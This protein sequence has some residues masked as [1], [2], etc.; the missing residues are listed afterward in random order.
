[1]ENFQPAA[2]DAD[3]RSFMSDE[4]SVGDRRELFESSA[5]NTIVTDAPDRRFKQVPR[6]GIFNTTST[7]MRGT[8]SV[9]ITLMF[10]FCGALYAFAGTHL[11]IEFGL[12]TPRH[13]FEGEEQGIPRSG[14]ALNY[15]QYA[16]PQPAYRHKTVVFSACVYGISYIILGNAAGNC[17]IFG[18]RMLEAADV[19]VTNGK[20]RG[21]AIAV[22]SAACFVHAFSRRGGIW[23]SNFFA[24]IKI[25]M[26]IL[27]IVT[28]IMAYAGGVFPTEG[29]SVKDI[30]ADNLPPSRSFADAATDS[31]GYAQAFLA[32]VFAYAGFEQPNSALGE[33]ARPRRAYPWATSIAVVLVSVLYMAVN[34]VYMVV[35]PREIQID[36]AQNIAT[37]FFQNTYGTLGSKD[38]KAQRILAAFMAISSLGNIITFTFTASRIKQE[39]AKE[40]AIPWAKLFGQSTDV[41]VGR[42]LTWCRKTEL[43]GRPFHSILKRK[44]LDPVEHSQPTP[45]G[46]LFLHWVFT[47]VLIIATIKQTPTDA[48]GIL[49]SLYSYAIV[50]FF[51]VGLAVGML[52]LRFSPSEGWR[53]KSRGFL[54]LLSILSSIVFGLGS[55]FPIIALWVPPTGTYAR[56]TVA[57]IA[58]YVTPA[59]SWSVVGFGAFWWVIFCLNAKRKERKEMKVFVVEKFPDFEREEEKDGRKGDVVQVHEIV[60]LRWIGK[61]VLPEYEMRGMERNSNS[62]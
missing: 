25:L 7:A 37:V 46:A 12:N 11:H 52:Y 33:I 19:E 28:G 55:L 1:M 57:R 41:S 38:N 20:A 35:V 26:L 51:G 21:I 29:R 54:P 13:E 44:I 56:T 27:I 45:V 42:F 15:L 53:Q 16:F 2:A 8:H 62:W 10:W 14:G 36:S 5:P 43:I 39:I 49:V 58:W 9:G 18:I 60:C 24:I 3:G 22:A 30:A 59:V 6:T 47:V 40:G 34:L 17:L 31:Y 23:L 50:A 61:E 4:N 48:Y 32:V